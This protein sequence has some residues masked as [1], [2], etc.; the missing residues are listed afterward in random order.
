MAETIN[1]ITLK[2][3]HSPAAEAFRVLRTNIQFSAID[4]PIRTLIVTSPT[5]DEDKSVAIANLAV[6]MA[7]GGR[8]VIL[9]DADLRRPAQHTIWKLPNDK[10][11]TSFI[12]EMQPNQKVNADALPLQKASVP[13]LSVL[14][15]GP[16]PPNPA[17][18][19]GSRRMEEVIAAL[20]Q[21]AEYV[22]FD[23]PPVL[24]VTDTPLLASRLDALLLVVKS[25]VTRRDHAQRAKDVLTR[26]NIRIVGV[27]MTNAPREMNLNYG[28][29]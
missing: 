10:G 26:L 5:A 17:D 7:Q 21:R 9:V 28:N 15:S 11:L 29:A 12:Q 16:L 27:A 23:A 6:T 4:K 13:G 25:G 19:I 22:L 14:T 18:L 1:L 2:E 3:P 24:V 20:S 8:D